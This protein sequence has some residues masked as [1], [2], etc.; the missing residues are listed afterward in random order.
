MEFIQNFVS[1][2]LFPI[3]AI[4]LS[5]FVNYWIFILWGLT[6]ATVHIINFNIFTSKVHEQHHLNDS[7][8]YG[9]ELYDIIFNNIS[10]CCRVYFKFVSLQTVP[11]HLLF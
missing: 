11:N 7:T 5:K 8:N 2:G 6:Y 4:F 1:Q 9:M 10:Y 3:I